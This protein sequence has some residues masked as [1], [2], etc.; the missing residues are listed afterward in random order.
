[1]HVLSHCALPVDLYTKLQAYPH[2]CLKLPKTNLP[3]GASHALHCPTH[4]AAD[5]RGQETVLSGKSGISGLCINHLVG[6]Q[7]GAWRNGHCEGHNLPDAH[8]V[9]AAIDA[10]LQ[11][12][13]GSVQ[14]LY[15][16]DGTFPGDLPEGCSSHEDVP[17]QLVC[18]IAAKV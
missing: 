6:L 2:H 17:G 12:K 5:S 10:S 7:E 16:L 1:M 13:A 4:H 8:K 18:S 3:C 9:W 14:R 15:F 11:N